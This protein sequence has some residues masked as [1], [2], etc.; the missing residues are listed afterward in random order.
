VMDVA[1][2]VKAG[3][4][5]GSQAAARRTEFAPREHATREEQEALA[6]AAKDPTASVANGSAAAAAKADGGPVAVSLNAASAAAAPAV[7]K[8]RRASVSGVAAAAKSAA[9]AGASSATELRRGGS[10][11]GL[12]AGRSLKRENEV[13]AKEVVAGNVKAYRQQCM[14]LEKLRHAR[15]FEAQRRRLRGLQRA[16]WAYDHEV[17]LSDE[18]HDAA[19]RIATLNA[20]Q[21]VFERQRVLELRRH[22]LLCERASA[23]MPNKSLREKTGSASLNIPGDACMSESVHERSSVKDVD[24]AANDSTAEIGHP[25][26]ATGVT[27]GLRRRAAD[28]AVAVASRARVSVPAGGHSSASAAGAEVSAFQ[29]VANGN[30]RDLRGGAS[31]TARRVRVELDAGEVMHDL[32]T[33]ENS[34][35]ASSLPAKSGSAEP[36]ASVPAR[37]SRRARS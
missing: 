26:G 36:Q 11:R 33:F 7:K 34:A 1:P 15:I 14:V 8:A 37:S 30:A 20:L 24:A 31:T 9:A 12:A 13:Y 17:R 29:A 16:Q 6:D 21:L 3:V 4:N 32:M 22:A 27:A 28:K 35:A 5:D 19:T 2:S 23:G 10:A 18:Q 25:L